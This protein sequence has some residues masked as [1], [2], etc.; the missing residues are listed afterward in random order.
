MCILHYTIKY[1]KISIIFILAIVVFLVISG[2]TKPL[3]NTDKENEEE[4]PKDVE[5]IEPKP[6]KSARSIDHIMAQ[7]NN[8]PYLDN[9]HINK[10]VSCT[11]CH[12]TL[13]ENEPVKL[14]EDKVCLDC[15]KVTYEELA[16]RVGSKDEYK[17]INPHSPAHGREACI[18][19]HKSHEAF[20]FTC[21]ECHT[22]KATERFQ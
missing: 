18:T 20:E 7:V 4:K 11:D 19:C 14:P 9:V 21:R 3:E 6:L 13:N 8:S 22:V 15:H 10:N 2:C 12:G 17:L 5:L 1:K 16:E